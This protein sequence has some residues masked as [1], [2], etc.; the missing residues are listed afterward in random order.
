MKP[1]KN[2]WPLGIFTAFGLFFAGMA[3]VVVIAVT[4]R[5]HLVN[6]NYYEQELKFQARIDSAARTQASGANLAYAAAAGSV[7]ITVPAAQLAQKLSGTIELYRPSAPD[8]DRESPL[9]PRADGTQT[10]DVSKLTPGLWLVRV[11]W[12]AAGA[13]YFLEQ[14]IAVA[15]N[16]VPAK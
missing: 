2:L 16:A 15:A 14:K 3:S 4:H 11:K 10:L 5:D 9:A 8:L 6:N 12:N 7:V 13:D 1:E